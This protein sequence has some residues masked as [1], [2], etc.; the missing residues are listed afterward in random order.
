ML[1]HRTLPHHQRPLRVGEGKHSSRKNNT[2]AAQPHHNFTTETEPKQLCISL[3]AE[4]AERTFGV[5]FIKASW[6]WKIFFSRSIFKLK[7]AP[8]DAFP[9]SIDFVICVHNWATD[10]MESSWGG[11]SIFAPSARATNENFPRLLVLLL[12][13]HCQW[14]LIS[15][16][17]LHNNIFTRGQLSSNWTNFRFYFAREF[18]RTTTAGLFCVKHRRETWRIAMRSAKFPPNNCC[19]R[20]GM[21][22]G[23]FT[24]DGEAKARKRRGKF[25]YEK[26]AK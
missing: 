11:F 8:L 21:R 12:S 23:M 17:S 18:M 9:L 20:W 19:S 7:S 5:K 14:K 22:V 6:K 10:R 1:S 25:S 26:E 15:I 13:S 4:L 3:R 2:K 16:N 24:D